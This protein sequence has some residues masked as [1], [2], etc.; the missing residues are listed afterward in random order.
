[1]NYF[2]NGPDDYL[3]GSSNEI[4]ALRPKSPPAKSK[5]QPF[6]RGRGGPGRGGLQGRGAPP[7]RGGPPGRGMEM[8]LNVPISQSANITLVGDGR[9]IREGMIAPGFAHSMISGPFIPRGGYQPR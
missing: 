7:G 1:M 8:D 9:T 4:E 6:A 3:V 5:N 2:N